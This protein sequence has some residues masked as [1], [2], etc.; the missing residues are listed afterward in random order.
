LATGWGQP[1]YRENLPMRPASASELIAR[2]G[3]TI[4]AR[5]Q[6]RGA[7][8]FRVWPSIADKLQ[9]CV[10]FPEDSDHLLELAALK[11]LVETAGAQVETER[12]DARSIA[13]EVALRSPLPGR[14]V[15]PLHGA[16]A[17][18]RSRA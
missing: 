14:I 10:H 9:I 3:A 5:F 13:V 2:V 11:G 17:R 16:T 6:G 8:D 7:V 1:G 12:A 18:A 15:V 4:I